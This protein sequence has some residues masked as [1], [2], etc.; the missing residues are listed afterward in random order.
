MANRALQYRAGAG[1]C[2]VRGGQITSGI[3]DNALFTAGQASLRDAAKVKVNKTWRLNKIRQAI[4]SVYRFTHV[5]ERIQLLTAERK[6]RHPNHTEI[7][8]YIS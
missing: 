3:T 8:Q 1:H 4:V 2:W 7:N 5:R 6:T